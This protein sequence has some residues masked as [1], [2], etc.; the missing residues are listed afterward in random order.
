MLRNLDQTRT[1]NNE[2]KRLLVV[3]DDVILSDILKNFS[4]IFF[5]E[6]YCFESAEKATLFLKNKNIVF[7]FALVDYFLPG[8]NGDSIVPELKEL[9]SGR[10]FLMSGDLD[11]AY[12]SSNINDIDGVLQKPLSLERLHELFN[13]KF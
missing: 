2:I 5:D 9:C 8:S 10:L 11:R 12:K 6:V 4:S 3:E 1:E 13:K 7:D